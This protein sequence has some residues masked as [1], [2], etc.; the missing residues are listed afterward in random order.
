MSARALR[1]LQLIFG[2]LILILYGLLI[3]RHAGRPLEDALVL[4]LASA[5]L[6][7][8]ALS[9]VTKTPSRL[10]DDPLLEAAIDRVVK[11]VGRYLI[12]NQDYQDN[13]SELNAGL[14]QFPSR[15]KVKDIIVGLMNANME[16]EAKVTVLSEELEASQQQIVSLRGSIQEVGKIAMLDSLTQLGNRRFFDHSLQVEIDRAHATG[17][18]LC[19]TI[20]DIDR[21]KSVNDRFGHVV[22]DHL[23]RIFADL[24]SAKLRGKGLAARYGGEEFA[25][26]FP[27]TALEEARHIVEGVRHELETQRWV[28]GPKEERLGSV[29]A[30]FGIAQ[31][32]PQESA[33]SFVLRA[34]AKLLEAKAWGRNRVIVDDMNKDSPT[35]SVSRAAAPFHLPPSSSARRALIEAS[36]AYATT[37]PSTPLWTRSRVSQRQRAV[38]ARARSLIR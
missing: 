26:L 16:M 5:G 32:L 36:C 11:G 7:G 1:A 37:K 13:L 3:W 25:L 30:S 29:T 9:G 21:F 2:A 19:L 27:N 31:L 33:E 14:S 18:R 12:L 20:A 8:V 23:L 10:T 6:V 35:Q 34:D 4:A 28:V 24:L 15:E 38:L 22:G 17:A